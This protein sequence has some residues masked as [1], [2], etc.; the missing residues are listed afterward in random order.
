MNPTSIYL[1]IAQVPDGDPACIPGAKAN[2]EPATH[3]H[4]QPFYG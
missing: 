1:S 4:N 3:H 2:Q